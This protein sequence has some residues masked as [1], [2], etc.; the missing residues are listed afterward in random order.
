M[1]PFTPNGNTCLLAGATTAPAGV[2]IGGPTSRSVSIMVWNPGTNPV[3]LGY[4]QD[5]TT[6]TANAVVPTGTGNNAYP[7]L[8]IPPTSLQTFTMPAGL[9]Y[10]A[11]ST[12]AAQNIFVTPGDGV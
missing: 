8:L 11:L 5:A 7:V 6:A 4:G 3:Y 9:F 1:I 10:S 2:Q 12:G